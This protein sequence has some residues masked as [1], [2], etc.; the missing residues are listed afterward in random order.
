MNAIVT[1]N[2]SNQDK[3][4]RVA[5]DLLLQEKGWNAIAEVENSYIKNFESTEQQHVI[6]LAQKE[7][8]DVV[9]NAEWGKLK[10]IIITTDTNYSIMET[11]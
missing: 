5:F 9:F 11:R 7:I 8:D 1:I 10:F 2:D 6:K 3:F 4:L